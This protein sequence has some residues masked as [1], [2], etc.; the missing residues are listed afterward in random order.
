MVDNQYI[1]YLSLHVDDFLYV[2]TETNCQLTKTTLKKRFKLKSTK[3]IIH[4]GIKI[5]HKPDE[6]L[7]MSQ[8]HYMNALLDH[9]NVGQMREGHVSITQGVA[10][11]LLSEA[12]KSLSV[13]S[14]KKHAL[15][16]SIVGKLMYTIVRMQFNIIFC[17][18]L[19]ERYLAALT[20]HHL[21]MVEYALAY[22]KHISKATLEYYRKSRP[23]SL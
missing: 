3:D 6:T 13:L 14:H 11:A 12:T 8:K 2:E 22:M 21:K 5:S 9:F 16:Q 7:Q 1:Y 19:L 18:G 17:V 23:L 20:S 15:Y 10:E 4:L